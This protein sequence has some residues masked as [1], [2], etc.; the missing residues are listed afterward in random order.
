MA[1]EMFTTRDGKQ[2]PVVT[3]TIPPYAVISLMRLQ[4]DYVQRGEHLS[5]IGVVLDVLDKGTNQVRNQ[6]KNGDLNKNRRLF[7]KEAAPY[8]RDP[9]KYA[10]ELHALALRYGLV[11]GTPVELSAPATPELSE[12]DLEKATQPETAAA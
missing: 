7:S 12:E 2:I 10:K 11:D 1:N 4:E 3:V 9:A 5:M 6:W 8:M